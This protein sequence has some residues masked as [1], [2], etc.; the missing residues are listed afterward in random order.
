M[1]QTKASIIKFSQN[2][3]LFS[4]LLTNLVWNRCRTGVALAT[5]PPEY[6]FENVY[7]FSNL[8]L[9]THS[10][11]DTVICFFSELYFYEVQR[12]YRQFW[13]E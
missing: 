10:V 5:I 3:I 1:S 13:F 6:S 9:R 7:L 4:I 8:L 11:L 2:N 12:K